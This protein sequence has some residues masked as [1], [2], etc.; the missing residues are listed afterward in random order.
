MS[1]ANYT[2]RLKQLYRDSIRGKM[3]EQ[4]KY[5]N[6]MQIPGLEKVVINM[7]VG[8]ATADSKKPASAA[9]ESSARLRGR[10]LGVSVGGAPEFHFGH[11][12]RDNRLEPKCYELHGP[13]GLCIPIQNL[14]RI[15]EPF[16]HLVDIELAIIVFDRN[17]E[18][19]ILS[20]I[21]RI[22]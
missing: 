22:D 11:L 1:D 3:K 17:R 12:D 7:G 21:P 8:E 18:L 14:V 10:S 15:V 19:K 2:P 9:E 16:A 4:F 6:D 20:R 13:F 5:T